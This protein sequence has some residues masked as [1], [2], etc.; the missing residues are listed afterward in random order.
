MLTFAVMA[1]VLTTAGSAAQGCSQL[2]RRLLTCAGD[3]A[4]PASLGACTPFRTPG[5]LTVWTCRP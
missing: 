4:P 5:N 1:I 2:S 3:A